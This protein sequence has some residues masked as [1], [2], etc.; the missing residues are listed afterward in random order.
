MILFFK[1]E[2]LHIIYKDSSVL[3]SLTY[4][5]I[6]FKRDYSYFRYNLF[7]SPKVLFHSVSFLS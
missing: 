4:K 7:F 1:S 6:G 5:G 3:P 2:S